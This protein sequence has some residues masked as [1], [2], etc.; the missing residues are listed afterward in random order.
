MSEIC[1]VAIGGCPTSLMMSL[2]SAR[3][4]PAGISERSLGGLAVQPC[5]LTTALFGGHFAP[6]SR[7]HD[8]VLQAA[9]GLTGPLT[10]WAITGSFR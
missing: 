10:W 2:H 4:P 3:T 7:S 8:V 5:A 1:R 9:H 6:F